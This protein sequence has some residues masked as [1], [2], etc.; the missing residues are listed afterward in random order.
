MPRTKLDLT[1]GRLR[2]RASNV[3]MAS[4]IMTALTL[5]V[6]FAAWSWAASAAKT[7]EKNLGNNMTENFVII[8][9]NFSSTIGKIAT[10]SFYNIAGISAYVSTIEV[11][12]SS[13]GYTNSTLSP[14]TNGPN[15]NKCAQLS[16]QTVTLIKLSF[17]TNL[18]P[19]VLYTFKAAGQYGTI[20]QYQ[21]VTPNTSPV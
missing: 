16:A 12:N 11:M 21:V 18:S 2:K 15:C 20:Q 8:N 9:A 4:V 7:T 13:W 19:N 10:L 5:S 1:K 14:S 6:G 17:G 3:V